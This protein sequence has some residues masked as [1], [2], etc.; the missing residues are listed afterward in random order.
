MAFHE[1][2]LPYGLSRGAR[3]GPRRR[4]DIVTLASGFEERNSNWAD[5]RR[6]WDL[7]YE[8]D[9]ASALHALVRFFEDRRGRL[10]GFRFRDY[11]DY[12]SAEPGATVSATDQLLGYGDGVT[13]AYQLVKHYGTVL[14][15]ARRITKPVAGTVQIALDGMAVVNGWAV[16]VTTGTVKFD[17][18][19]A[20]GI[21]VTA[22][23]E[24]DVPVRFKSE[25]LDIT[26]RMLT[27]AEAPQV[28]IVEL[29]ERI[30]ADAPPTFSNDFGWDDVFAD[31]SSY[32]G[33]A[34][35]TG[36]GTSAD[37]PAEAALEFFFRTVLPDLRPYGARVILTS[38]TGTMHLRG[39]VQPPPRSLLQNWVLDFTD[40]VIERGRDGYAWGQL[41]LW[42]E[43]VE[44][45]TASPPSVGVAASAGDTQITLKD[46]ADTTAF[47]ASAGPGSIAVV[48]TN[49]TAPD[50][51]PSE[52][53]ETIYIDSIAGRTLTPVTPVV[54]Q[55]SGVQPS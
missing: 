1:I 54:D 5:S 27:A 10:Y 41:H 22:G 44:V 39:R 3:G 34:D 40:T 48:R 7:G 14:P 19:P 29:K 51:H 18:A 15:W 53:R 50:Y 55:R 43:L 31:Y 21:A 38:P 30:A 45:P 47:V 20:S 33:G 25:S 13:T 32:A 42:G 6:E 49:A 37:R 4:T 23:F 16:D 2:R 12:A 9:D 17:A 26:H 46:D 8:L 11:A 52:S 35:W 24:F 28:P 36:W